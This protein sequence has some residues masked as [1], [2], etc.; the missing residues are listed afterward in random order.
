MTVPATA[1]RAVVRALVPPTKSGHA[2]E[3]GACR[4]ASVDDVVVGTILR[5]A[6]EHARLSPGDAAACLGLREARTIRL[7]TGRATWFPQHAVTLARRYGI[8]A[9]QVEEL[10][11]LLA[12]EHDHA[13]PDLGADRGPMLAALESQAIAIR[14][15]FSTVCFG[16]TGT[17]SSGPTFG[18]CG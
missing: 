14:V 4:E 12:A 7:E 2:C 15:V 10:G 8:P 9:E 17:V 16:P 1:A 18:P 11:G 5:A 3:D 6:R 13:V